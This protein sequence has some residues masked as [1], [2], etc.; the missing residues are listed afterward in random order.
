M[1]YFTISSCSV[2]ECINFS[3][4]I[5]VL[6]RLPLRC[7]C[8]HPLVNSSVITI[9]MVLRTRGG[10]RGEGGGGG[11]DCGEVE[12]R[13]CPRED[14]AGMT[15]AI[16][17]ISFKL[18]QLM[19]VNKLFKNPKLSGLPINPWG[20]RTLASNPWGRRLELARKMHFQPISLALRECNGF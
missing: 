4:N 1:K 5:S 18:S 17:P 15:H 9:T 10:G 20:I 6:P 3:C 7:L 12:L 2:S 16:P 11:V 8:R 19:K 14:R 13:V